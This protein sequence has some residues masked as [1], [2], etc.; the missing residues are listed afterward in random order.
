[1]IVHNLIRVALFVFLSI[2]TFLFSSTSAFG[3]TNVVKVRSER[4]SGPRRGRKI[5]VGVGCQVAVLDG[6]DAISGDMKKSLLYMSDIL[7]PS[8]FG[9]T[10]TSCVSDN[11]VHG[12]G[13]SLDATFGIASH[14]S[15][16]SLIQPKTQG[17]ESR[18]FRAGTRALQTILSSW[19]YGNPGR[20]SNSIKGID[21]QSEVFF[22][23]SNS[24]N[25]GN[26]VVLKANTAGL[27]KGRIEIISRKELK[28]N[29]VLDARPL[30]SSMLMASTKNGVQEF[31]WN[32]TILISGKTV[33]TPPDEGKGSNDGLNVWKNMVYIA[34]QGN[35]LRV[36][37]M[38]GNHG[39]GQFMGTGI[40]SGWMGGVVRVDD[41]A[42]VA[43]DPGLHVFEVASDPSNPELAS[44]CRIGNQDT[45]SYKGWNL[46][47][48][49]TNKQLF[50]ADYS[51]G[52]AVLQISINDS[53]N[54]K[55]LKTKVIGHF[56]AGVMKQ[57]SEV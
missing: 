18:S 23:S 2:S 52:L 35:G 36:V 3:K 30:N 21:G 19:S 37:D 29:I 15:S 50:L 8:F 11:E 47:M 48:D 5:Y 14:G 6:D 43:A 38:D 31:F 9:P 16:L 39:K 20:I 56:G 45:D 12:I 54:Q 53:S 57:C 22:V 55:S 33:E 27:N 34:A 44:T 24:G 10:P 17:K 1:M 25:N 46:A 13:V 32:G 7:P 41:F 4:S 26:I 42:L 40:G 51:G 49:Y 28:N